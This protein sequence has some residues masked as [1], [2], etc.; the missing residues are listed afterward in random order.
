VYPSSARGLYARGESWPMR[1]M[2][3]LVVSVDGFGVLGGF[4]ENCAFAVCPNRVLK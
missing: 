1:V 4:I 3:T 2:L